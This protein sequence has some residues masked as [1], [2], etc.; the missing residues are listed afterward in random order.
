M[1]FFDFIFKRNKNAAKYVVDTEDD[2]KEFL[3]S[4][5]EV[6][7]APTKKVS[8]KKKET[9]AKKP[10][11]KKIVQKVDTVKPEEKEE[12]IELEKS[13]EVSSGKETRNGKFDLRRAKDGRFFFTL[14]ASNHAPIA[15]SQMY[16]TS[17]AAMRGI[18]SIITNSPKAPTE[19]N[20]LKNPASLSFPKWEIYIDRAGE[21]RFRLYATN[22]NCICHS[23]HGYSTKSGCKG[24][25]ESIKR[26][27]Q[28][29][30]V[31][32]SYLN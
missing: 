8:A 14:Y 21:F 15:F 27:A 20:T 24:G 30:K 4:E 32:K 29:A 23:S 26:F 13:V 22:G 10:A 18:S 17:S 5:D 31:D 25:I 19:D 12:E 11:E 1:G 2:Q 16:S 6:K 28:E 3:K 9:S 7:E